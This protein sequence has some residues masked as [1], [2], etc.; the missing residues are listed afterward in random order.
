LFGVA[1]TTR[2]GPGHYDA[3]TTARVYGRIE[4]RARAALQ[5]GHSVI[6]DAVFASAHERR[7]IEDIARHAGAAFTGIWLSAP[8]H[9]LAERVE[10][11]R[12]DA[13]DANSA[14]VEMQIERGAGAVAWQTLDA[15][16]GPEQ[17]AAA[18]R[19]LLG[20]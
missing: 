16:G 7:A 19:K 12:G 8:V 13:S 10:A 2:L 11:R 15:S 17:V 20:L 18:A 6:A 9:E 1:E 4:D 3:E 14:V 5:A